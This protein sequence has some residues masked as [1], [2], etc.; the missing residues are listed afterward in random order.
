[1]LLIHDLRA[2][3]S[4]YTQEYMVEWGSHVRLTHMF[5]NP[6]ENVRE[7]WIFDCRTCEP[8]SSPQFMPLPYVEIFISDL[9][10][11]RQKLQHTC[12]VKIILAHDMTSNNMIENTVSPLVF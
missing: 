3:I 9:S 12:N 1:M 11:Q 4:S 5:V 2:K 7:C 8:Y 6:I 10:D